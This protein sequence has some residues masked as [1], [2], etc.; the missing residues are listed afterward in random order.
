M[1]RHN[2][3]GPDAIERE[4]RRAKALELREQRYSYRAIA[5]ELGVSLDTAH[6]DVKEAMAAITKEPAEQVLALELA[7]LDEYERRLR[8]AIE[9]GDLDR[10]DSALRVQAR[11]AKLLGLDH[12]AVLDLN[13]S[14]GSLSDVDLWLAHQLGKHVAETNKVD[15]DTVTSVEDFEAQLNGD[16]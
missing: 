9:G 14:T 12:K 3:T 10:I 15:L 6:T 5:A 8:I 2:K 1:S 13:R 7:N 4:R 11:R 16:D